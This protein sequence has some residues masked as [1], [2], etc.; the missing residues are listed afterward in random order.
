MG[1]HKAMRLF[2]GSTTIWF[3]QGAILTFSMTMFN[4]HIFILIW[5]VQQ[6]LECH[7]LHS[8]R[9]NYPTFEL[10]VDTFQLIEEALDKLRQL[11]GNL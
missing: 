7:Q 6:S 3:A 10:H 11:H 9:G 4:L 2:K 5:C 1:T 8:V